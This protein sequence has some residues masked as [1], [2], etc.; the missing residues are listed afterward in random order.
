MSGDFLR[1]LQSISFRGL[2]QLIP[3]RTKVYTH[4]F[5]LDICTKSHQLRCCSRVRDYSQ[6][7][8]HKLYSDLC[9]LHPPSKKMFLKI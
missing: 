9:N 5:L 4:A 2:E 8:R 6:E 7:P 3:Q 1:N